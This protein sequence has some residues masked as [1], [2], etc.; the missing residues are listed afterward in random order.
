MRLDWNAFHNGMIASDGAR[1]IVTE[2]PETPEAVALRM[3]A[4]TAPLRA[5]AV[6]AKLAS[7]IPD[8]KFA[9]RKLIQVSRFS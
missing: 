8:G 4:R 6:L 7:S 1:S 3:Y 2:D 9:E 5:R